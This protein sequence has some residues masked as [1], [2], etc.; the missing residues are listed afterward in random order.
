ME[1]LVV[2]LVIGILAAI[3]IPNMQNALMRAR[4]AEAVGDLR[5]VRQAAYDYL[6]DRHQ[7]PDDAGAGTVPPGLEVYLPEGWSMVKEGYQ[8]N[9]ENGIGPAAFVGVAVDV[10][11]LDFGGYVM[12]MLGPNAWYNGQYRF[13]WVF[14]WKN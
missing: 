6:G 9:F 3:A 4:A 14:E 7:W 5:V 2:V 1:L 12:D 8:L 13:T 11:D 10:N